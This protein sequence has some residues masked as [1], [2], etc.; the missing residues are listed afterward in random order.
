M[1]EK[2]D[3]E[4][5]YLTALHLQHCALKTHT[6]HQLVIYP[7]TNS[8]STADK[9]IHFKS[10]LQ[11]GAPSVALSKKHPI[12]TTFKH[13]TIVFYPSGIIS[14]GTTYLISA[15]S[16]RMY[17]ISSAVSSVSFLRKYQYAGSWKQYS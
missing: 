7:N 14:T 2:A 12:G 6:N 11:F 16:S 8:Y 3:I 9:T 1:L 13:N 15:T 17:A 4:Q 5:F 10:S